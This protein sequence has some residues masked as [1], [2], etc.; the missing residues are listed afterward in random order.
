MTFFEKLLSYLNAFTLAELENITDG[1]L[2]NGVYIEER[3][4]GQFFIFTNNGYETQVFN[5]T[6]VLDE[7]DFGNAIALLHKLTD[8]K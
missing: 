5:M 8:K 1:E 6:D 3:K 2:S 7:F 4:K